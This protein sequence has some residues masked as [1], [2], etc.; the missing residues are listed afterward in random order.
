MWLKV[1]TATSRGSSLHGVLTCLLEHCLRLRLHF[2]VTLQRKH[3]EA[4]FRQ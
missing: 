3:T 2:T 1:A 4:S